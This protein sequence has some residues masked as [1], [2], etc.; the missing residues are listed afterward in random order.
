VRSHKR[1]LRRFGG[2]PPGSA[3]PRP[4]PNREDFALA[5][6]QVAQPVV[7]QRPVDELRD[8]GRVNDGFSV[9]NALERMDEV[10]DVEEVRIV[11]AVRSVA[12]VRPGL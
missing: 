8:Q 9:G 11:R 3:S 12:I 2:T 7:L 1:D 6:G 4:T 10:G 5:R